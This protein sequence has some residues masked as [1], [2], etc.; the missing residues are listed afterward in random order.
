MGI[1][2]KNIDDYKNNKLVQQQADNMFKGLVNIYEMHKNAAVEKI[3]DISKDFKN[4]YAEMHK[5]TL[6]KNY[7]HVYCQVLSDVKYLDAVKRIEQ[8]WAARGLR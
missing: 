5:K 8:E 4:F 6:Y 1:E 3:D 2:Y 7:G